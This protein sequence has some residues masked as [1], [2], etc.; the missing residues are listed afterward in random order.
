LREQQAMSQ[1]FAKKK[2]LSLEK[3]EDRLTPTVYGQQWLNPQSL[4]LSFVANG[5][6][7]GKSPS[8]LLDYLSHGSTVAVGE[9]EILRAFQTWAVNANLNIGVTGEQGNNALG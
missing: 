9:E 8:N 3:L 4:T 2:A 6:Q 5:T 7:V 1:R